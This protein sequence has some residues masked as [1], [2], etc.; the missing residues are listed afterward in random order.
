MAEISAHNYGLLMNPFKSAYEDGKKVGNDLGT[1]LSA[2]M[3]EKKKDAM[4]AAAELANA[5][6]WS[7]RDTVQSH[8]P[9]KATIEVGEDM[10]DGTV[11]GIDNKTDDVARAG[12]RQAEALLDA[13]RSQEIRGQNTLLSLADRQA[14]VQAGSYMSAGAQNSGVLNKILAAIEKGQILTINKEL[15]VGATE[16]VMDSALGERQILVERGAL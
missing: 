13:Y 12:E 6:V 5:P 8:S 16:G 14:A 2:G 11:I 15:L 3:L 7:M 1:G 9:A 4:A 10:G